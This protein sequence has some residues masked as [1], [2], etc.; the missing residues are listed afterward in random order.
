[1]DLA[2]LELKP[3]DHRQPHHLAGQFVYGRGVGA[4]IVAVLWFRAQ[5]F[6]GDVI[7]AGETVAASEAAERFDSPY[8]GWLFWLVSATPDPIYWLGPDLTPIEALRSAMDLLADQP[9]PSFDRARSL[10]LIE[11]HLY[12]AEPAFPLP[13]PA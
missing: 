6:D 9:E 12:S 1:M 13:F 5:P 11:E 10:A 7:E 3:P 4:P 2:K 8:P